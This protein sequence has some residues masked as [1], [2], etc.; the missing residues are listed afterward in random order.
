[1][2]LNDKEQNPPGGERYW[3]VGYLRN[4]FSSN[5]I[6]K[7]TEWLVGLAGRLRGA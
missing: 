5:R 7:N 6:D 3:I 1:M 4:L 2:G